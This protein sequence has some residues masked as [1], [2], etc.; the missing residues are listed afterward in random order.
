MGEGITMSDIRDS[1]VSEAL[2]VQD[3][4]AAV[5]TDD[6]RDLIGPPPKGAKWDLSVPYSCRKVDGKYQTRGVS[7]CGLVAA[8]ILTRA[9]FALPWIGYDYWD[10]P[11]PYKRLDIVSALSQ[12]GIQSHARKPPGVRPEPGDVCCIGSSLA[13]HVLTVVG[14]EGDVM[15]S[16]DG[17]Q[18]DDA[19]HRF[20]QRVK[21]CRRPWP[22]SLVW[23]LD[24]VELY[25]WCE[26]RRV[27]P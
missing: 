13:T 20:L 18:V 5:N 8:G 26:G 19:A 4:R 7:T 12:I 24:A 9:G 3:Y 27:Y 25:A 11:P 1:V 22:R 15:V 6:F 2:A 17:G 10:Y 14:W 16:V 23:C 21:V